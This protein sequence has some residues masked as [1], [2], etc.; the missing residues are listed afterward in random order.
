MKSDPDSLCRSIMSIP[1][2]VLKPDDSLRLALETMVSHR[3][4]ALPIAERDGRYVGMLPRSRLVALAMPRALRRED[5]QHPLAHIQGGFI[6]DT[7]QTLQERI[8]AVAEDPVRLHC[9]PE[10]PVVGPEDPL[11]EVIRYLHRER[12]VLPVVDGGRLLG[13]VTVWDVLARLGRLK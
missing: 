11:M 8:D 13:V 5:A 10:A 3:V 12:T 9:D 1:P 4:P 7:L 6:Q 2:A